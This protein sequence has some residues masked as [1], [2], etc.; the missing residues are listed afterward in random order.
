MSKLVELNLNPDDKTLRQFGFIALVGFGLLAACAYYERWIFG[1][2]LGGARLP[3]AGVFGVAALVS[4][5]FALV[6]PRANRL[7]FVGTTLLAFPIGFV[8]SYVIMGVLFFLIIAPVGAALRLFG[9]DPMAR[10][11]D[12]RAPTYWD[13]SRTAESKDRYLRQC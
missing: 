6:Y 11:Y 4:F 3:V 10:R 5:V 2:G 8:L 13:A 9:K 7:I 12:P 1:F